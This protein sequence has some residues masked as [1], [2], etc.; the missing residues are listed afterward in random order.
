MLKTTI[1]SIGMPADWLKR[2]GFTPMVKAVLQEAIS[3]WHKNLLPGHFERTAKDRYHYRQRQ[4][5]TMRRKIGYAHKS[6]R[7]EATNYLVWSGQLRRE[8]SRAIRISGSGKRATGAM[9]GPRYLYMYA[10]GGDRLFLGGEI[11]ATDRKD[12]HQLVKIFDRDM[13]RAI[14]ENRE[15]TVK[16]G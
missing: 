12:M 15:T 2:G 4:E 13:T 9:T 16:R 7:H 1:I 5:S 6:G 14:E 11:G 3:Y 8:V 10:K